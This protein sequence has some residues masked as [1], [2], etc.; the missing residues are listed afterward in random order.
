LGFVL[1]L[2]LVATIVFVLLRVIPGDPVQ[3]LLGLNVVD[4]AV[5][6]RLRGELGLDRPLIVQYIT[7]I[8]GLV[9]GDLGVSIRSQTPVT[10]LV[11][12]ALP[13]TLELAS[14]SLLVGVGLSVAFGMAAARRR[15]KAS[16]VAITSA[17]L[18]GISLPSFVL[19]LVAIYLL[20]IQLNLLPSEGFVSFFEDP[21]QNLTL[22]LM[23]SLT[24]GMVSAGILV[25]MM[26]RN[27]IDQ[28]DEDYIRTAR[29]K[30]ASEQRVF[31]GHAMRNAIMPYVTI[32]GIEAGAL[33]S[34]SVII[35]SIFAIPGMGRLMITSIS[36][37]DYP[38]VQGAVL[39][40][41]TLYVMVNFIVDL[42]Y[43]WLDP[44]VSVQ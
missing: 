9:R 39:V 30:G 34:G 23:P 17:A 35:E 1:V 6:H 41:A 10:D 27:L 38:V 21:L 2:W 19:G 32:A 25:R 20:S 8:G 7:W 16:D 29:A 28:L 24:L 43:A 5:L 14:L 42:I 37:R 36:Q 22:M 18:V 33:L 31:Y 15:G 44:R 3:I 26:R 4:P 40:V 13:V 11:G 12:R